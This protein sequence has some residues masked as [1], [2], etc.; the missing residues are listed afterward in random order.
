V[1]PHLDGSVSEQAERRQEAVRQM[2]RDRAAHGF[3]REKLPPGGAG[4]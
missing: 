2:R 3:A 4:E 1:T